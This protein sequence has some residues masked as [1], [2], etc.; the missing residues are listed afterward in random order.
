MFLCASCF[1]KCNS[2]DDV[3]YLCTGNMIELLLIVTLICHGSAVFHPQI[4]PSD[5]NVREGC[6]AAIVNLS[7]LQLIHPKL[8]GFLE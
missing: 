2:I 3:L 4:F 1:I 5:I 8:M 6:Q 7:T